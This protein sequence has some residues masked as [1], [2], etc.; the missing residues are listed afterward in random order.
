[1]PPLTINEKWIEIIMLLNLPP[2][3]FLKNKILNNLKRSNSV[4]RS[5]CLPRCD[6]D[7]AVAATAA[8]PTAAIALLLSP[9]LL[10]HYCCRHYWCCTT[11]VATTAVA[12]AVSLLL[13]SLLLHLLSLQLL[14]FTVAA[15]G[16]NAWTYL[17]IICC[18]TMNYLSLHSCPTCS[19]PSHHNFIHYWCA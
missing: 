17:V 10:L 1:M 8:N 19:Y 12:T 13:L 14:L 11:A 9:L 3:V 4:L 5:V 18:C 15:S 2:A 6:L 7:A 16:C